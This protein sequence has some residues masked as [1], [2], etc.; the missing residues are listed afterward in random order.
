MQTRE[1]RAWSVCRESKNLLCPA[2]SR[3]ATGNVRSA[4]D[5]NG[6]KG[7]APSEQKGQSNLCTKLLSV[8]MGLVGGVTTPQLECKPRNQTLR[9]GCKPFSFQV[10]ARRWTYPLLEQGGCEGER[11]Y[12]SVQP[13]A[14]EK[15]PDQHSIREAGCLLSLCSRASL[16]WGPAAT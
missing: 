15:V 2:V 6:R 12:S 10:K 5:F 16:K 14:V 11:L 13:G 9:Q 1:G 3:E 4:M 8:I 7:S